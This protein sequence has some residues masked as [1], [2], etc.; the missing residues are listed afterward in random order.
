MKLINIYLPPTYLILLDELVEEE[1]YNKRLLEL[2][3]P[4]TIVAQLE[5]YVDAVKKKC[6]RLG[7][8]VVVHNPTQKTTT[9]IVLLKELVILK[10]PCGVKKC[11]ILS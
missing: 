11:L 6:R 10:K 9:S 8:E 3:R 5:L 2:R 4:Q 1:F 7:I